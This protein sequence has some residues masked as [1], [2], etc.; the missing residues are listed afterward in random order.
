MGGLLMLKVLIPMITVAVAFLALLK[1][2]GV[3]AFPVYLVFVVLSDLMAARFFYQ[4]TTEG[5]L[6][7]H[8]HEY[9]SIRADGDPD[10]VDSGVSW[11]RRFVHSLSSHQR[12]R[13]EGEDTM[14]TCLEFF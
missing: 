9:Q 7:R 14:M 4:V 2:Q 3:P 1:L 5:S 6:A 13:G 8:W 11:S 12:R 10:C